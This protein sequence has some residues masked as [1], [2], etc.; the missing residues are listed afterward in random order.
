[1]THGRGVLTQGGGEEKAPALTHCLIQPLPLPF[2]EVLL[3]FPPER[4]IQQNCLGIEARATVSKSGCVC[5]FP[6]VLVKHAV[7]P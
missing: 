1:M 3:L 4:R 6:E 2:P 5:A 7:F